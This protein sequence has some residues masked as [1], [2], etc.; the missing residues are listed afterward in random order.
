V[1]RPSLPPFDDIVRKN[2]P[3][4]TA[5]ARSMVRDASLIDDIVQE[6]FI[7]AW[8]Y[9]PTFRNEG[10]LQG[11]LI[12]ICQNVVRSSM[13]KH[14][15][16]EQIDSDVVAKNCDYDASDL[17]TMIDALPDDHR[18]IVTLCIVLGYSYEDVADILEIPI[19]TVRSRL[20]RARVSL[21]HML[22]EPSPP[23]SQVG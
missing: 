23:K 5:F 10:S 8:R 14:R 11:W 9:L 20:S 16:I 1:T 12:R 7:R 19:G 22:S 3:A 18:A 2:T 13:K 4:V 21:Q 6:T 17:R 15:V